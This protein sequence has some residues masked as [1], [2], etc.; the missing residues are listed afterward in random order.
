MNR[1][2]RLNPGDHGVKMA[3]SPACPASYNLRCPA[4]RRQTVAEPRPRVAQYKFVYLR[5]AEP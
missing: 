3:V 1:C 5:R 4:M 2:A